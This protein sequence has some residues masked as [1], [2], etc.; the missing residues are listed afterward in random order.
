MQYF[1]NAKMYAYDIQK[2]IGYLNK[3]YAMNY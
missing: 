3:K 1:I 2:G